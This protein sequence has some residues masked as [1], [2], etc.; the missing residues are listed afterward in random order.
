MDNYFQNKFP[1]QEKKE[2]IKPIDTKLISKFIR[3][4]DTGDRVFFVENGNGHWVKNPKTFLALGGD[5]KRV[6]TVGNDI[7]R[8]LNT[9]VEAIDET[10]VDTFVTPKPVEEKKVEVEFKKYEEG[11]KQE[12]V[13]GFTSIII[14]AYFLNL[15]VY[16]FTGNCIG[17]IREHTDQTKTPYEII[18]VINDDDKCFKFE[19]L[20]DTYCEKII[21]NKE[22]KGYTV[23]INQGIRAS[24]GEYIVMGSSDIMVFDHW[25]EDILEAL[26][27][28]DLVMPTPMYGMP[29]ARA[30]EAR[31]LREKTLGKPI[32]ETFLN[33][34]DGSIV[35]VRKELF[36]EVGLMD[37]G[38]F[39]YKSD[40]DFRKRIEKAGKKCVSTSRVNTHHLVGATSISMNN[41]EQRLEQD[42]KRY[43]E[44]WGNT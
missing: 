27:Y 42:N 24:K 8:A 9:S 37:E 20:E 35:A 25:L 10:N 38:I 39:L 4:K 40:V 21:V 1:S 19:H 11:K 17:S 3:T 23:A 18:L 41:E 36:N 12:T 26:Q 5:F 2:N 30:V 44:L 6:D 16:H 15:P 33:I 13:K 22:N 32:Q 14:P 29:F 34:A 31:K 7:L 43:K 28:A